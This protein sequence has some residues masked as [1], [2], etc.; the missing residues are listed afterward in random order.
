MQMVKSERGADRARS[1]NLS[2]S[3][4]EADP[5]CSPEYSRS[6]PALAV[7]AN[8]KAVT[9]VQSAKQLDILRHMLGI[10]TPADR[11]P[12]PYRN[13]YATTRDDQDMAELHSLG[14]VK[15]DG[16]HGDYDY[17]SCTDMG[18]QLA[19]KSHKDIRHKKPRRVYLKFLS[20]AD[21]WPDLTFK[22]FL[23]RPEFKKYRSEA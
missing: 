7:V 16:H 22:E 10:N 21:A 8:A 9:E 15:F 5:R 14:L 20:C 13:Y 17:F 23:T 18:R 2:C 19:M 3:G 11:I 4:G 1:E 6:V 12:K